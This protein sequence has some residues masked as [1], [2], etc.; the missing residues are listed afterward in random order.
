[1]IRPAVDPVAAIQ[2]NPGEAVALK[3]YE[4]VTCGARGVSTGGECRGLPGC[5][6]PRR[7]AVT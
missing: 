3:I 1:M 6:R 5:S 7:R 4:P 2:Q